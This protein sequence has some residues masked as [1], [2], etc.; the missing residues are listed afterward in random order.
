MCVMYVAP[1]FC[2]KKIPD[3]VLFFA[4]TCNYNAQSM[5][6]FIFHITQLSLSILSSKNSKMQS[7]N[8]TYEMKDN[9]NYSK[10]MHEVDCDPPL[11]LQPCV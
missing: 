10:P 3:A 5:L 2:F 11:I 9:Q 8:P 1:T 4:K 7:N 6:T